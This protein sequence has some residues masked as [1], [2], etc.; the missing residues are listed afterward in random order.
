MVVVLWALRRY[1]QARTAVERALSLGPATIGIMHRL[2]GLDLS[3]GKLAD[4]RAHLANAPPTLARV[5]LYAD[6][7]AW[8]LDRAQ[9]TTLT[10]ASPEQFG[11]D[12]ASRTFVLMN[13]H[14]RLGDSAAAK[15]YA[16]SAASAYARAMARTRDDPELRARFALAL[17][18]SGRREEAM[19]EAER[20]DSLAKTIGDQLAAP[21]LGEQIARVYLLVGEP[22]KSVGMLELVLK[23]PG[24][25]TPAY[26]TIDPEFESLRGNARYARLVNV[27]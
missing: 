24:G 23:R 22:E 7:P 6:Q 13:V 9:L 10:N 1:P 18:R 25:L 20:A 12:D 21:M 8:L 3:E 2:I 11:D 19:H 4:A 14:S 26:L 27:S 5:A 16:D 15:A 17:A